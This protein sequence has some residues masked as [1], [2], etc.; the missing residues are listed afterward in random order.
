MRKGIRKVFARLELKIKSDKEIKYQMA[1][2]F[3]GVL[4][5]H[6]DTQYAEFLHKS[7]IHPYTSHLEQQN[8]EWMW[9]VTTLNDE[10][11]KFIIEESLLKLETFTIEN[12]GIQVKIIDKKLTQKDNDELVRGFYQGEYPKYIEIQALTPMSFKQKG[13]YNFFPDIRLIYQSIMNKFD[14]ISDDQ[15]F[16]EDILEYLIEHTFIS[17]YNIKSMNFYIEGVKIP[18][19][20][21][22]IKLKLNGSQTMINFGNILFGFGEYS[23]IGI[24]TS[25]GMG[26]IKI[27]RR[28]E[29][30]DRGAN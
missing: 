16:D 4:M 21:G 9:I 1:S 22:K 23:G 2:L 24:K 20:T 15:M 14:R 27:I 28:G 8:S 17:S 7:E 26:A 19:W 29:D 10:A 13:R 30:H 25:I 11:Y 12:K 3:H 6:I 18:G 5:E